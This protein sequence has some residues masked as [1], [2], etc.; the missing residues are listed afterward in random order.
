MPSNKTKRD[1]KIKR[2]KTRFTKSKKH[3]VRSSKIY[4]TFMIGSKGGFYSFDSAEDCEYEPHELK[5]PK[6]FGCDGTE[7]LITLLPGTIVDRFGSNFGYYLGQDNEMFGKRSLPYVKPLKQ[8]KQVYYEKLNSKK[9][10]YT[11]FL[12]KKPLTVASCKI[13]SAFYYDGNGTQFRLVPESI[14]QT[15]ESEISDKLDPPAPNIN[16]TKTPNIGELIKLGY[17]EEITV[18]KIPDFM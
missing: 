7:T 10:R 4:K 14:V 5:W 17:L 13:A 6:N 16:E 2:K 9:I 8:C 3:R 15:E 12:I 18:S 1:I 11:R